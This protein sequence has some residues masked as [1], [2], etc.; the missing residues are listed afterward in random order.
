MKNTHWSIPILL[1]IIVIILGG[2]LYYY[3]TTIEGVDGST[4]SATPVATVA[5]TP[6]ATPKATVAATPKTTVAATVAA[7]PKTTVAA[8]VAATPKTTVAA[9]PAATVTPTPTST[10]TPTPGA[11]L[12][13]TPT[14]IS[15]QQADVGGH[16]QSALTAVTSGDTSHVI[17]NIQSAIDA[18]AQA[19]ND[20][21]VQLLQ[22]ALSE[23]QQYNAAGDVAHWNRGKVFLNSAQQVLSALS[24]GA[25]NDFGN[26]IQN[27]LKAINP[28]APN[29]DLTVAL[30]YL[31]RAASLQQTNG[32]AYAAGFLKQAVSYLQLQNQNVSVGTIT[33][34]QAALYEI[35]SALANLAKAALPGPAVGGPGA[36][37]SSIL[38]GAGTG[39]STST[40]TTTGGTTTSTST[41]T[42]GAGAT[43]TTTSTTTTGGSWWNWGAIQEKHP[44]N[45]PKVIQNF[46]EARAMF[47]DAE[48]SMKTYLTDKGGY[49]DLIHRLQRVT[50]EMND[51]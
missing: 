23:F 46:L 5:A 18:Q 7:T 28:P 43:S 29:K 19:G 10:A 13:P 4:G 32:N 51:L 31:N 3:K 33:S 38:A 50:D 44:L 24:T 27:A 49:D 37:M 20:A 40:S 35:A 47:N 25:T 34:F 9:T 39:T 36:T 8:T 21:V 41:S 15:F 48:Q 30:T 45:V 17:S 22:V 11:T 14:P 6:A 1:L 12:T 2:T 16:I 42:D 26:N